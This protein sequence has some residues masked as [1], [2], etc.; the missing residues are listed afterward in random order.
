MNTTTTRSIA[1]D[2]TTI[3]VGKDSKR[4]SDNI[5]AQSLQQKIVSAILS[6]QEEFRAQASWSG[7]ILQKIWGPLSWGLLRLMSLDVD[8]NPTVQFNYFQE[9][10]D[11]A[12]CEQGIRTLMKTINSTSLVA[13]QYTNE[14][15]PDELRPL[16]EIIESTW[17]QRDFGN[18]TQDSINIR[19]WCLD[20]VTTIWH[21]HGGCVVGDVVDQDYRVIGVQSLRVIDGSTFRKSPGTN[22]QATVMMMGRYGISKSR[23][24]AI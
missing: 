22:P 2:K 9:Q 1:S 19:Q 8:E 15:V 24:L 13:L 3:N 17:P 14:S 12:T 6:V 18:M 5:S 11:L 4:G 7:V 21:Y 20:T 23:I 10:D 16:K